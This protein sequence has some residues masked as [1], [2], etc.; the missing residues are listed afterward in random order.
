VEI[1][2]DDDDDEA[3]PAKAE[4]ATRHFAAVNAKVLGAVLRVTFLAEHKNAHKAILHLRPL[5]PR[6]A[7]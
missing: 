6:Q 7:M 1:K 3:T 2:Y 5:K 4:W